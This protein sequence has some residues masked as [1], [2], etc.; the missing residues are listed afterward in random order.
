MPTFSQL[1]TAHMYILWPHAICH[2]SDI[3][4]CWVQSNKCWGCHEVHIYRLGL[5]PNLC[6]TNLTNSLGQ[7]SYYKRCSTI[8]RS[9]VSGD[10]SAKLEAESPVLYRSFHLLQNARFCL[11][12]KAGE[13]PTCP[14]EGLLLTQGVCV[15]IWHCCSQLFC[16]GCMCGHASLICW[17]ITVFAGV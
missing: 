15:F 7:I 4:M 6:D 12:L 2:I 14:Q 13:T 17:C 1:N 9:K 11:Q 8:R 3:N 10:F 5:F 16:T